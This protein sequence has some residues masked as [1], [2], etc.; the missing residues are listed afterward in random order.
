MGRGRR[1]GSL[2]RWELAAKTEPYAGIAKSRAAFFESGEREVEALFAA[3]RRF[4]PYLEIHDVL[5]LG[6]GP[7]RLLPAFAQRGFRVT[8]VD[9]SP[10]MLELARKNVEEPLEL[11]DAR[12]FQQQ[13]DRTYDIINISRVLQ[14]IPPAEGVELLGDLT[15]R[16]NMGGVLHLNVP[17][18]SRRSRASQALLSL[19]SALPLANRIVNRVK[20][21][22]PDAPVFPPQVYSLDEVLDLLH[23][24][25]C[26]LIRVDVET[27]NELTTA[28]I[29]ARKGHPPT[30][31]PIVVPE[32]VDTPLSSPE[33]SDY[34]DPRTLLESLSI[35]ELNARAEA[36][37]A[38]TSDWSQQ[39]AK[40]FGSIPDSPAMLTSLGVLLQGAQLVPGMTVLDFGGGTGWLS[41]YLVQLGCNVILCDVAPTALK[42]AREFMETHP[43]IGR[44]VG[45]FRTIV[46]DG[47][48][49]PLAN[50]EVD[51]IVC[52]DAFHHVP[53]ADEVLTEFARVLKPGGLAAFS[54]PGPH[55]SRSPQ[56]QFEMRT[57]AVIEADVDVHAI[58]KSA[59]AAG[60]TDLR[61]AAFNGTPAFMTLADFEELLAGGKALQTAALE[62]RSFTADVRTFTLRKH[63][64]ERLDSRSISGL[65]ATL[66]VELLAPPRANIPTPFTASITNTGKQVWL[67]SAEEVGGVA[68]GAHLLQGG[69]VVEFEFLPWVKLGDAGVAPNETMTVTG[70]VPALAAGEYDIEF[71]CVASNI[72]WFSQA[73]SAAQRVRLDVR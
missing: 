23:Q 15:R 60:F 70:F 13:R 39:L 64:T 42:I 2:E 20:R 56:S 6:C 46:F 68:L 24:S 18:R 58:W 38:S 51:R 17:F 54:E 59:R 8:G 53:N 61:L 44:H 21:R 12:T 26:A 41:R 37:F 31:E 43:P 50:E 25:G 47:H 69:T 9:L 45:T 30:S 14:H 73:G 1:K 10:S 71:D 27:E 57:Y 5:E 19:R 66:R 33:P 11:L 48:D 35:E 40:P 62:M 29:L 32:T 67:P 34:L 52:F 4:H 72:T 7:G 28:H 22:P 36:Y 63:G 3:I 49:I 55:H 16:L 65:S